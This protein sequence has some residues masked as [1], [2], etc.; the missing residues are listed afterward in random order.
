MKS[1]TFTVRCSAEQA[2]ALAQALRAYAEA[3]YPPGGSECAQV[4][5]ET[6]RDSAAAIEQAASSD[7]GAQLRR[8]QRALIR[9]AVAWY[10]NDQQQDD[11]AEG[12]TLLQ[13]LDQAIAA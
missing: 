7:Q 4:A 2:A 3:A 6:L 9:T 1:K 10:H 11:D 8:R 12:G 5:R 13:L